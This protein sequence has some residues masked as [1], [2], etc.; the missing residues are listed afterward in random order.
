MEKSLAAGEDSSANMPVVSAV[1][2]YIKIPEDLQVEEGMECNSMQVAAAQLRKKEHVRHMIVKTQTVTCNQT[3]TEECLKVDEKKD[4]PQLCRE[5]Q[6]SH[7]EVG[8]LYYVK[9]NPRHYRVDG[10][11]EWK[12]MIIQGCVLTMSRRPIVVMSLFTVVVYSCP[13]DFHIRHSYSCKPRRHTS[14]SQIHYSIS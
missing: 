5:E 10:W 6:T 1:H 8:C 11:G 13:A 7:C 9:I 3:G 12:R 4:I 14:I 2:K